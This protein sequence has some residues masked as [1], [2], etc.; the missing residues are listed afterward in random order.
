MATEGGPNNH[1]LEDADL[2]SSLE[3]KLKDEPQAFQFFQ[4]VRLLER[5]LPDRMPVGKF[6][7]P[8]EEIAHFGASASLAFPASEIQDMEWRENLPVKI[9]TNFMGLTGAL[10]YLPYWYSNLAAERVRSGDATL[11]DFLRIFDHRFISLFY[12]AWERYRFP[13][14]YER[15][16]RDRFS[17][18]LLHLVGMGTAGLKP[19]IPIEEETFLYYAGMFAQRPRSAEALR[20]LLEDYFGVPAEIDQFLGSWFVLDEE[21][22]SQP[23]ERETPSENLGGGMVIGDGVWDQQA[24]ARVRLGPLTLEQYRAFLPGQSGYRALQVLTRFFTSDEIDFELQLVLQ[25]T[26]VPGCALSEGEENS[27]QLGWMSWVRATSMDRDLGDTIL[28]L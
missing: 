27:P 8:A 20:W 22:V 1:S 5:L 3:Q 17:H 10:G 24:R 11:Q 9:T 16:D 23:G 2:F 4:A 18:L 28:A 7:R 14:A 15:G 12:Q 13:V 26:Q 25:R 19:P 6:V 21:N